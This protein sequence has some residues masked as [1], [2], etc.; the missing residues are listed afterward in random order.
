MKAFDVI[1]GNSLGGITARE[2]CCEILRTAAQFE[3][4][5]EHLWELAETADEDIDADWFTSILEQDCFRRHEHGPA[6]YYWLRIRFAFTRKDSEA[7]AR[8]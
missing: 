6:V 3:N 7:S 1:A 8:L 2:I 5:G 4:Q